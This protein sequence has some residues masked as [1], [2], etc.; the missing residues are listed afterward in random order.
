MVSLLDA[1]SLKNKNVITQRET[2]YKNAY[3]LP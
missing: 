2:A 3:F 1:A